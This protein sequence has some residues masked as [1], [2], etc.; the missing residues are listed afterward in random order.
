MNVIDIIILIFLAFGAI[1]GFRK[2]FTNQ[3]VSLV[4][5]FAII[6][7]SYL[8]KNPVSVF[9][10]NNLPFVNFGGIFK[11]ITVI[12]IL[13]YEVIAFFVIFVILVLVF[14]IL[15]KVTSLFEKVLKWTIILGIPSKIL[16]ALLGI[17]QNLIYTF[18]ILYILNLPTVGFVNLNDAKVG[19]FILNKTPILTGICDESLKVFNEIGKLAEEYENT[20]NVKEFNQKTLNLMIDSG[21][22][23]KEN[24]LKLIEKGKIKDVTI[25]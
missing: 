3:L 14:K 6:I 20:D 8:L 10:Y 24:V 12:N 2:G 9:L 4:G 15:L 13:V 5:V 17:I 21:V 23:T 19:S 11:D 7:F 22:I 18:I 1:M 16:G 25:E